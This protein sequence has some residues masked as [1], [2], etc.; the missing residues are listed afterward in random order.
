MVE[1]IAARFRPLQEKSVEIGVD[2]WLKDTIFACFSRR[3][4]ERIQ[5][6]TADIVMALINT[7]SGLLSFPVNVP[8]HETEKC[9]SSKVR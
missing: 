1:S 2:L 3:I 6:Y 8:G 7:I 9:S 5:V 4:H